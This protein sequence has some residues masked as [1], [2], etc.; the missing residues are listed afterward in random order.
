MSILVIGDV[1]LD[2]YVIGEVNRLSPEAPIPVLEKTTQFYKLGGAANVANNI[3][4]VKTELRAVGGIYNFGI[5]NKLLRTVKFASLID[6]TNPLFLEKTRYASK[7]HHYL[8]RVDTGTVYESSFVDND[9]IVNAAKEANVVVLSDYCKGTITADLVRKLNRL[10]ADKKFI[11]D[12]KNYKDKNIYYRAFLMAPNTV[13]L[14][15]LLN[16]DIVDDMSI[17]AFMRAYEVENV[18]HTMSEEGM[19]LH[20]MGKPPIHFPVLAQSVYDVTGAGDTVVATIAEYLAKGETLT[21][22]VKEAN[23]RAAI[24]IQHFGTSTIEG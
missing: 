17:Q 13:E 6:L 2:S 21:N 20:T 8:L 23:R 10:K 18:L 24:V 15:A 12:S 14:K 4:D 19:T 9:I 1:I 11:I 3:R 16:K 7:S 5:Y 22:A